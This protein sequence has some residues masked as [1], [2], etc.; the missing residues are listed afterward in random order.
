MLE[1]VANVSEGRRADVIGAIARAA[2]ADLLDVHSDPDHHRTVLTVVGTDAPPAIAVEAVKRIDLR[3]HV[4]VHPRIGAVDVVPFVPLAGATIDDAIAARNDFA[5]WAAIELHLPCFLYGPERSLP[6]IRRGAF[7]TLRPD[8]GPAHAHPTAGGVAVGARLALVA[9]NLWLADGDG[10]TARAVAAE[11]RSPQ[12]RALGLTVGGTAQVSCNLLAPLEVGPA[13][14]FDAVAARAPVQRAELVGLLSADVL[15][16]I[17]P[18]RW[19]ELDVGAG[20]TI[21]AR[22]ARRASRQ[23]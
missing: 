23:I 14:V 22:L 1:C 11:L 7:T 20:R 21:E 2:G 16:R 19:A 5:S 9:Y 6:D 10:A 12:V 15:D 4:G 3:D 8:V 18:S 17:P 13:E